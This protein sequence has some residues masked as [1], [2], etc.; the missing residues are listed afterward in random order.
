MAAATTG[1]VALSRSCIREQLLS[2]FIEVITMRDQD[3]DDARVKKVETMYELLDEME[4][5]ADDDSHTA[6]SSANGDHRVHQM[7]VT[8]PKAI[9]LAFHQVD[10][11]VETRKAVR[12]LVNSWLKCLNNNV[13]NSTENNTSETPL[14]SPPT[15]GPTPTLLARA[16]IT[17]ESQFPRETNERNTTAAS[18]TTTTATIA[19]AEH[20]PQTLLATKGGVPNQAKHKSQAQTNRRPAPTPTVVVGVNENSSKKSVQEQFRLLKGK[21]K[22]IE[23]KK[24]NKKNYLKA[25]R[26]LADLMRN[27]RT[28][29]V[30]DNAERK[31]A[32]LRVKTL[33]AVMDCVA[34]HWNNDTD[35]YGK[36]KQTGWPALGGNYK[37]TCETVVM[38]TRGGTPENVVPVH[39]QHGRGT[40]KNL[41]RYKTVREEL[42]RIEAEKRDKAALLKKIT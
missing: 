26:E 8:L 9:K 30:L 5:L 29:R 31:W 37:C 38:P 42:G 12:R 1:V 14:V 22:N 34:T 6:R 19:T 10:D 16:N 32:K 27:Y 35:A 40:S 25:L 21:I 7:Y 2:K 3:N 18:T 11:H 20:T 41:R 39:Q 23:K 36:S 17:A 33:E 4:D 28:Q 13:T 15:T 24:Q